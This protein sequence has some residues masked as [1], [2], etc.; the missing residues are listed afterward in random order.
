MGAGDGDGEGVGGEVLEFG[1]VFFGDEEDI[2]FVSFDFLDEALDDVGGEV[3][4]VF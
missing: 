2:G 4:V 3:G 1:P